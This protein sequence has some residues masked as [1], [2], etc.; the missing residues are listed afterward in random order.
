MQ[1][2]ELLSTMAQNVAAGLEKAQNALKGNSS[3][4][5][6]IADLA[7]NTVDGHAKGNLTTDYGVKVS[8]SDNWLKIASEQQTGPHLLEDQIGREKVA[9]FLHLR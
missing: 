4:N 9:L 2:P 7:R 6:K 3:Q 8:N 5:A 1:E